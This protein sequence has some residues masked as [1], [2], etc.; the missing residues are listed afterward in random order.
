MGDI[1]RDV[2]GAMIDRHPFGGFKMSGIGL[3]LTG[4]FTFD[5]ESLISGL[6]LETGNF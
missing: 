6:H 5:T 3:K 1:N 2:T 4:L